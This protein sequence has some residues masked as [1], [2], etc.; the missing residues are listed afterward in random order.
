[1]ADM[2]DVAAIQEEQ[3]KK[4]NEFEALFDNVYARQAAER[5]RIEAEVLAEVTK[6]SLG[7]GTLGEKELKEID[8]K[9]NALYKKYGEVGSIT[10]ITGDTYYGAKRRAKSEGMDRRSFG[11]AKS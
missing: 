7:K 5:E 8:D 4:E 10:S 9:I 2:Y 6:K 1:M 11:K 3:K